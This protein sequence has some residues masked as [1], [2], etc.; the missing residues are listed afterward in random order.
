[1]FRKES[2]IIFILLVMLISGCAT[3]GSRGN[4]SGETARSLDVSMALKFEDVPVP[5][6][7]KVIPKDT[8]VFSNE[9]LRVGILKYTGRANADQVVMFYQ[10]QM[11]LYNWRLLNVLEYERRIMNFD[12]DDQTCIIVVEPTKM[13]THVTITVAPKG[14]RAGTYRT[15]TTE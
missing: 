15:A 7:F 14:G 1:M 11:P 10:D 12:R 13:S 6:G 9:V 5:S 2:A 8:F 3:G 4:T